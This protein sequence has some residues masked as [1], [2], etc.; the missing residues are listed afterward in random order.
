LSEDIIQ[1]Q[2]IPFE[3]D[4]IGTD[5]VDFDESL[6]EETITVEWDKDEFEE[7]TET[8]SETY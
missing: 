6:E 1:E 4:D 5:D 3:D 2:E 7:E 8:T